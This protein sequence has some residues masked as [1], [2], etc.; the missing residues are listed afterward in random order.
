MR[1]LFRWLGKKIERSQSEHT[2]GEIW[3]SG[4]ETMSAD[5]TPNLCGGMV[6]QIHRAS[7]G[8]VVEHTYYD[9]KENRHQ[10]LH[11][12]TDD[13]DMGEQLSKII[14]IETLRKI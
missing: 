5:R 6:L 8:T 4:H 1:W 11:I 7:G 10:S 3:S 12:I 2:I 13:Q 14:T 9:N